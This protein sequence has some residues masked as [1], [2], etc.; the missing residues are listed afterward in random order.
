MLPS[1]ASMNFYG[2]YSRIYSDFLPPFPPLMVW[3]SHTHRLL[4]YNIPSIIYMGKLKTPRNYNSLE[5][6]WC[7]QTSY[8]LLA[9]VYINIFKTWVNTYLYG[10]LL[11][12]PQMP[13][14]RKYPNPAWLV[15]SLIKN[16]CKANEDCEYETKWVRCEHSYSWSLGHSFPIISLPDAACS[17]GHK[18]SHYDPLGVHHGSS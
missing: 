10:I 14:P 7:I 17:Y 18:V 11:Y 4:Q 8:H 5:H 3:C 12:L 16:L 2:Y 15:E 6:F 9:L 13:A 1:S